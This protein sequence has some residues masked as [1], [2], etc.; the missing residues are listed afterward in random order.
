[1]IGLNASQL[2]P[3][4]TLEWLPMLSFAFLF[5]TVFIKIDVVLSAIVQ[6]TTT[7]SSL[8]VVVVE[9][10]TTCVTLF[11]LPAQV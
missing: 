4:K 8:I 9:L 11:L 5:F 1:M 2:E 7:R 3:I 10:Q 6:N